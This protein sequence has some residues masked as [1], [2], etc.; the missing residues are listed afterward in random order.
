MNEKGV[1]FG[2]CTN[3]TKFQRGPTD[4]T[5]DSGPVR[6]LFYTSE[7]T[8]VAAERASTAKEACMIMAELVEQYGY[9]GTGETIPVADEN[10]AWVMEFMPSRWGNGGYWVARKLKDDE[11]FVA[12]NESRFRTVVN[13]KNRKLKHDPDTLVCEQIFH[14]FKLDTL[15]WL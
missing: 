7:L 4:K 12:G 15:D 6:R 3:G 13:P 5:D 14:D 2:E 9:Y 8:N 10:E 11:V 1:S